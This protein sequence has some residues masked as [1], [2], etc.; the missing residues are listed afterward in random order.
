MVALYYVM[1][2]YVTYE[3][4]G[5]QVTNDVISVL[6]LYIRG[7]VDSYIVGLQ[8]IIYDSY[9]DAGNHSQLFRWVEIIMVEVL[10]GIIVNLL[11]TH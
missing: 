2:Q 11:E 3:E 4:L 7:D 6:T 5:A 9:D 10:L 8:Q 1:T